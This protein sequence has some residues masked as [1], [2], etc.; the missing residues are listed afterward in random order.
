VSFLEQNAM[1]TLIRRQVEQLFAQQFIAKANARARV[2]RGSTGAPAQAIPATGGVFTINMDAEDFDTDNMFDI[3][4]PT[5]LTIK[6]PGAY[7]IWTYMSVTPNVASAAWVHQPYLRINGSIL[8][9]GIAYPI[10]TASLHISM[11]FEIRFLAVNDY[12][13]SAVAVSGASG[14]SAA[15]LGAVRLG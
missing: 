14:V 8:L 6:T 9:S 2:T 11:A 5:R 12:I 15:T 7:A 3:A 1:E 4:A 10:A 13:E